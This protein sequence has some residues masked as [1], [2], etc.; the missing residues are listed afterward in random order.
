MSDVNVTEADPN[1]TKDIAAALGLCYTY[2]PRV[3]GMAQEIVKLIATARA[4]GR[5]DAL[6]FGYAA[7]R[8]ATL[9][10]LGKDPGEIG[11]MRLDPDSPH[12]GSIIDCTVDPPVVRKVLG[13]LPVTAD[14]CVAW[15][16]RGL[17]MWRDGMLLS[18]LASDEWPISCCYSTREL[19]EAAQSEKGAGDVK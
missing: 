11:E 5:A 16:S 4:E 8:V 15:R 7:G 1:R 6:D 12:R 3:G 10:Q 13:T 17:W 18:S 9:V 2:S 19:A 14:G